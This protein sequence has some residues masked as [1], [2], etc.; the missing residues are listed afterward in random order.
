MDRQPSRLQTFDVL[1]TIHKYLD[2]IL[3]A[4]EPKPTVASS[5]LLRDGNHMA[6]GVT[7]NLLPLLTSVLNSETIV[8]KAAKAL[9]QEGEDATSIR[10]SYTQI[11]EMLFLL[12]QKT[13]NGKRRKLNLS[14]N[15]IRL[16]NKAY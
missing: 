16:L 4:W 8:S 12:F 3:D 6:E 2:V 15:T 10:S 13:K 7:G 5:L 14:L 11:L 9:K 1:Q